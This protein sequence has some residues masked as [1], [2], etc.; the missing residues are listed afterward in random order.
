MTVNLVAPIVLNLET[1][2]G[3]QVILEDGAYTIKHRVLQA[4]GKEAETVAA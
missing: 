3:K 4:E 1:R 2:K